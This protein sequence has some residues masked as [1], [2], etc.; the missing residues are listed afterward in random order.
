MWRFSSYQSKISA[1]FLA[2]VGIMSLR[3]FRQREKKQ[4]IHKISCMLNE[5]LSTS[6]LFGTW[7]WK[8]AEVKSHC[9]SVPNLGNLDHSRQN[10]MSALSAHSPRGFV[11]M[12]S[13]LVGK[14]H[15]QTSVHDR[16]TAR[17][18]HRFL[19]NH[20]VQAFLKDSV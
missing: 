16:G 5:L 4:A 20:T 10:A 3:V 9:T 14:C 15:S 8:P 7:L 19:L 6:K 17:S 1:T 12:V 18:Q 11:D 13:T 2:S